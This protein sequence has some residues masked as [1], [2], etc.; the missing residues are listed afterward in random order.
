MKVYNLAQ[1]RGSEFRVSCHIL[2][3][4]SDQ[5]KRQCHCTSDR[6]GFQRDEVLKISKTLRETE[7]TRTYID[8]SRSLIQVIPNIGT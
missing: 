5:R 7:Y 6:T 8:S 3:M 1:Q 4:A 2:R